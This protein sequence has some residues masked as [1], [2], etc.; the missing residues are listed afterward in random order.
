MKGKIKVGILGATGMVGQNYLVLLEEHPWFEVSFLAASE[1]SAGKAYAE[2]VKGRWRMEQPLSPGVGELPVY[3]VENV[4]EAARSCDFVFSAFSSDKE[5][6]RKLERA[7]AAADIPVVSNNSAHRLV[8][9]VPVIM[10]EVNPHHLDII[11]VQRK[12]EGW[13]KGFIVTKPN[14]AVQSYVLPLAALR[15]GGLDIRRVITTNL[16]AL[17]G[18][19]YPG[20]SAL[21]VI[22]NLVPLPSEEEKAFSEPQKIFGRLSGDGIVS[23]GNLKISSACMRVPVV[24]G[25]TSCVWFAVEGRRP[26]IAEMEEMLRIF[27]GEPQTRKLP[28]APRPVFRYFADRSHPQPRL[29]RDGGG[30]MA[31][32]VGGLEESPVL[33]YRFTSLSHNTRR[34]AAGGAVLTA[35]LLVSRGWIG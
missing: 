7:Y 28:S 29:D 18:A 6:T 25:H 21:D 23:D 4:P 33:G 9:N 26:G 35:E 27:T 12:K 11:G 31:V 5:K 22:D 1:R 34:G 20:Q 8:K 3:G 17:S 24:H 16:Q 14:C 19:G 2:A 30:G 32:T 13:S 10:P 15:Q